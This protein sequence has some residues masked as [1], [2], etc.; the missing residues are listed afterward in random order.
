MRWKHITIEKSN[1][2]DDAYIA[3]ISH[4]YAKWKSNR[5][6]W[7]KSRQRDAVMSY[8]GVKHLLDWREKLIELG[9]GVDD[10]DFVFPDWEGKECESH[11]MGR[12]FQNQL[13]ELGD[14][15]VGWRALE[16]HQGGEHHNLFCKALSNHIAH[17]KGQEGHRNS[18]NDEQHLY[19]ANLKDLLQRVYAY[20]EQRQVCEL[21]C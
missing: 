3:I 2:H 14:E 4:N 19:S 10:D 11:L 16:Q 6:V 8:G 20:W 9:M 21:V 5:A 1:L 17:H 12:T 15:K 18:F 13:K 7:G